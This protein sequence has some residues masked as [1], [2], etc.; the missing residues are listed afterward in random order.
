MGGR[1]AFL[2][3]IMAATLWPTSFTANINCFPESQEKSLPEHCLCHN[4]SANWFTVT[5]TFKGQRQQNLNLTSDV[6]PIRMKKLYISG[7]FHIVVYEGAFSS[8][9][10]LQKVEFKS[11]QNLTIESKAFLNVETLNLFLNIFDCENVHIESGAFENIKGRIEANISKCNFVVFKNNSIT[12][13]GKVEI[14]HVPRLHL[15]GKVFQN[16]IYEKNNKVQLN[17]VTVNT[18]EKGC[19]GKGITDVFIK[20]SNITTVGSETFPA[21]EYMQIIFDSSE[22]KT[23]EADALRNITLCHKLKFI[24]CTIHNVK[25]RAMYQASANVTF[26][27][28]RFD[29]IETMAINMIVSNINI[30]GN[31]FGQM[32]NNAM[33]INKWDKIHIESNVFENL[34]TNFIS[35]CVR[36]P[37]LDSEFEFKYNYIQEMHKDSAHFMT[38]MFD[39]KSHLVKNKIYSNNHFNW[40]C[41]CN[42]T[43]WLENLFDVKPTVN[44]DSF[45]NNST[46]IIYNKKCN[47][48]G[49]M[50]MSE[51]V[52]LLCD[53][54]KNVSCDEI[55]KYTIEKISNLKFPYTFIKPIDEEILLK[56][57]ENRKFLYLIILIVIPCVTVLIVL[58]VIFIQMRHRGYCTN[59]KN[60]ITSCSTFFDRLF[61]LNYGIDTASISRVSVNDYNE[62]HMLHERTLLNDNRTLIRE[63]SLEEIVDTTDKATQTLPEELTK[64]LLESLREKLDDPENYS[65]ARETI[66]HLYDLIKVEECCN[67]N[68]NNAARPRRSETVSVE[69]LYD[70]IQQPRV[71]QGKNKKSMVSVGTKVPSFEKLPQSSPY[72]K[73]CHE[74]FEPQDRTV[75]LYS[76]LAPIRK[77]TQQQPTN[78]SKSDTMNFLRAIETNLSSA[79][80]FRN[81]PVIAGP[82]GV[83]MSSATQK[84]NKSSKS[85]ASDGSGSNMVNRPLPEK[86]RDLS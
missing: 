21:N 43:N 75:H 26:S 37:N 36:E 33:I 61:N 65:E 53:E 15:Y 78:V 32:E 80:A 64:E 66:E 55:R 31:K 76:E 73:L 2:V 62:N 59:V 16:V 42:I 51:Y 34:S 77:P 86:P 56:N 24:N 82:S 48:K 74:Y 85:V 79:N 23:I 54:N 28:S 46:C 17:N 39:K 29:H 25:S 27:H 49:H 83:G 10:D 1:V 35:D 19:F 67:M 68:N 11:V 72:S 40:R 45:Q 71:H 58:I 47:V 14:N 6:L 60:E 41:Y 20:R 8:L 63:N 70:V 52:N 3:V 13:V 84:S 38:D 18:L 5:C 4:H 7:A 57:E 69:N 22:I 50:L 9:L 81:A 12:R 30:S 44:I